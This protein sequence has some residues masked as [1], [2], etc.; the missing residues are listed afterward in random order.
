M[1]RLSTD[2]ALR[3]QLGAAAREWWKTHAT[4]GHAVNAWEQILAEARTLPLASPSAGWI[5]PEDGTARARAILAELGVT[6]DL[7]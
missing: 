5:P 1:R 3:E 6:V 4:T 7:F 2:I